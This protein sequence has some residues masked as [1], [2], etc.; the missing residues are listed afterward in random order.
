[1]IGFGSTPAVLVSGLVLQNA[2]VMLAYPYMRGLAAVVDPAGRVLTLTLSIFIFGI[3][4]TPAIAA[5]VLTAGYGFH[6]L[7]VFSAVLIVMASLTILPMAGQSRRNP[8]TPVGVG[9]GK[10]ALVP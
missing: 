3:G 2:A 7:S 6:G 8:Q 5:L 9:V 10:D 4:V 1:M